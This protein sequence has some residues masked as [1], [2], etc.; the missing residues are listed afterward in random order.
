MTWSAL[1]RIPQWRAGSATP[2]TG[3]VAW[4]KNWISSG[5]SDELNHICPYHK[6]KYDPIHRWDSTIQSW[7]C[8]SMGWIRCTLD[9]VWIVPL[10]ESNLLI[11]LYFGILYTEMCCLVRPTFLYISTYII[12]CLTCP[13]PAAVVRFPE[14]WGVRDNY[15]KN[16]CLPDSVSISISCLFQKSW[17]SAW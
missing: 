5:S 7:I 13:F 12:A 10:I 8:H 2:L 16:H 6:S 4:T 17:S 9:H 3:S 11:V 14:N 15:Q 1:V